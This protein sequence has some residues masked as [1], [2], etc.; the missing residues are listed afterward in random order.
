MKWL[1]LVAIFL[2][3]QAGPAVSLSPDSGPPGTEF[4]VAGSDFTPGERLKILWDGTNLGGTIKVGPDG[5]FRYSATVPDGAASGT[6]MIRVEAVGGG[7]VSATEVFVV[8][9]VSNTTTTSLISTTTSLISTTTSSS[10]AATSTSAQPTATTSAVVDQTTVTPT[11]GGQDPTTPAASSQDG[12][13]IV[14]APIPGGS[15]SSDTSLSSTSSSTAAS[16]DSAMSPQAGNARPDDTGGSGGL[17]I[18]LAVMAAVGGAAYMLWGRSDE[19]RPGRK[20]GPRPMTDEEETATPFL[21]GDIERRAAG[22]TRSMIDLAPAGELSTVAATPSALIG[23]GWATH[24]DE[25]GK[26]AVWN[27]ADGITWEGTASLGA[28][29]ALLAVTWRSGVL[30]TASDKKGPRHK[31]ACW[32][33]GDGQTWDLLTDDGDESLAG[34][35]FEGMVAFEEVLVGWGRCPDGPGV[36]M[37]RDGSHWTPSDLLGDYD[38]IVPTDAGLHAFGRDPKS[39]RPLVVSSRDGVSWVEAGTDNR[40]VFEGTSVASLVSF[41][42]GSVLVGTDLIRGLGAIWVTDDGLG[43]YRVPFEPPVGTS[44]ER[45]AKV[46]Q[47]LIAVGSDSRRR[48]G[49]RGT[50][51]VWESRDA[52]TWERTSVSDLFANAVSSCFSSTD[53]SLRIWGSLFHDQENSETEPIPVTWE[54]TPEQTTTQGDELGDQSRTGQLVGPGLESADVLHQ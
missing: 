6:H 54:L 49:G 1:S 34:V 9:A 19:E 13:S 17:I 27:S 51:V 35:S 46:D 23:V 26:V 42:G 39:R 2:A 16:D 8:A 48:R 29:G 25:P 40:A 4:T 10:T 3:A 22:W 41:Q 20:S 32:F 14:P 52:V 50:V 36:W 28:F 5:R 37:S 18:I 12:G 43:W 53:S 45:I 44:F 7:S 38:L 24:G 33:S 30:I 11:S 47:S 31:V 15:S 21:P